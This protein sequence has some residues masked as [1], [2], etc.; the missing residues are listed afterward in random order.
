MRKKVKPRC[1]AVLT[2]AQDVY[3]P[4][5]HDVMFNVIMHFGTN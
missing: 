2:A 4:R 3:Q 1:C 5:G